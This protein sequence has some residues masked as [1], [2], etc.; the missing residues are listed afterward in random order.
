MRNKTIYSLANKKDE[1]EK[2]RKHLSSIHRSGTQ[3]RLT[4]SAVAQRL[5]YAAIRRYAGTS[6]GIRIRQHHGFAVVSRADSRA[7]IL[8]DDD[9]WLDMAACAVEQ[10]VGLV[11]LVVRLVVLDADTEDSTR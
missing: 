9:L 1:K 5:A 11:S 2:S 3:R 4:G 8:L 7:A 10:R 6:H